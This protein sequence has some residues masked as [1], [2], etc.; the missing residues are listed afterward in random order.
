M[1]AQFLQLKIDML[2]NS[3]RRGPGQL[4]G[5]AVAL[6]FGAI[7]VVYTIGG[8]VFL[9][10]VEIETTRTAV[11]VLGA[12]IVCLYCVIPFTL[13]VDDPEDPRK[14]ALLGI[15]TTRLAASLAL[16]ALVGTPSLFIVAIA[17]GQIFTWGRAPLP[18]VFAVLAAIVIVVT[19]VLASRISAS[20]AS[21]VFTTRRA[22]DR[23]PVIGI[24]ILIALV[25]AAVVLAGVDWGRGGL[26]ALGKVADV[27]GWTPLGAAWAAPAAAAGGDVNGALLKLLIASI[28]AGILFLIWRG[29]IA[30]LAILPE[31]HA[32][33]RAHVGLGWF[34]LFPRTPAGA[35]AARTLTYWGRDS[36]YWTSFAAI[37]AVALS[38]VVI[39]A[40]VG[41]DVRS[42]ALL[43]IAITFLFLGWSAHNDVAMDNTA[44]WLNL[45]TSTSGRD[46]RWGRIIPLLVA[47]LPLL[48]LGSVAT[49]WI[50]GDWT[51]LPAVVGVS[52]CL[53]LS[54][55]GISSVVSA[56]N[57]YAT[58]RPGDSPFAAPQGNGASG[59]VPQ[60]VSLL[61]T[62]GCSVPALTAAILALNFGGVWA[63]ISCIAGLGVGISVLLVGISRG[64]ALYNARTSELLEFALQN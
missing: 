2:R 37:P 33:S 32:R 13:G 59:S 54:G 36:R 10:G 42:L 29:V 5:P 64:A 16:S 7:V 14:F 48:V 46:D 38:L 63:A 58:V 3:I 11:I 6:V 1:V 23:S 57:P 55:L 40:I 39:F 20:L 61:A 62:A 49:V 26:V 9:R 60:A 24:A 25:P 56:R 51:L 27:I 21:F 53:L 22:R 31:R 45:S 18:A 47:G 17:G 43:P 19:C 44:L 41:V 15:P 8:L 50:V 34:E 12:V 35:I 52:A 30:L 4:G 28:F